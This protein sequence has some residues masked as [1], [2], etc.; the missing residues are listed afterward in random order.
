[1]LPMMLP[2]VMLLESENVAMF[3]EIMSPV[4]ARLN[5]MKYFFNLDVKK[6]FSTGKNTTR[7]MKIQEKELP[8]VDRAR[9]VVGD[10]KIKTLVT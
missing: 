6:T 10:D 8:R 2:K 4:S 1:M 5:K 7:N 3:L 9:N